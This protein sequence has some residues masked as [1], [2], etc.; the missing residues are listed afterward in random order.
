MRAATQLAPDKALIS[1]DVQNAFGSVEWADALLAVVERAPRLAPR[2]ALQWRALQMRLWLH[3]T[4]DAGWHVMYISE[5]LL[6]GGL[7]GHPVFCVVIGV[8]VLHI[9]RDQQVTPI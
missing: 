2:L 9:S 4:N 3:N 7:D 1:L 8:V 6:Q 5:S